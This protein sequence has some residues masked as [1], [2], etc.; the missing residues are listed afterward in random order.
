MYTLTT[1]PLINALN[2]RHILEVGAKHADEKGYD[3]ERLTQLRLAPDMAT[4]SHQVFFAGDSA[5]GALAR[6]SGTKAPVFE[7]VETSFPD[8]IAR[9]DKTIDFIKSI[10][11]EDINGTQEKEIILELR[12][13]NIE[14]E[15]FSYVQ[16]F[17]IPNV[18]FHV[19]TTYAIL[20]AN[21]VNL[22]KLDFFGGPSVSR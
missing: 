12:I 15:G 18:L 13:G 22:G 14:F 4:L 1:K 10:P 17:A 21:G 6:L 2:N 19:S 7:D 11:A 8:L 3:G 16:N 5:K 9:V 20:R